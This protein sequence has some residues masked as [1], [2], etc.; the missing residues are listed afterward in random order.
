M[1][2]INESLESLERILTHLTDKELMIFMERTVS[3]GLEAR[4]Q[5]CSS[6]SNLKYIAIRR[7]ILN[8]FFKRLRAEEKYFSQF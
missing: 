3:E 7:A 5:Q 1:D 2:T 4:R 6:E 8:E